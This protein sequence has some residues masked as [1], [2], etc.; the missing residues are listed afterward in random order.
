M[1]AEPYKDNPL[2]WHV[3]TNGCTPESG[4]EPA[5]PCIHDAS[6]LPDGGDIVCQVLGT[7]EQVKANARFIVEAVNTRHS[8]PSWQPIAT[9]PKDGTTILL[10]NVHHKSIE[11]G[12]W[13]HYGA[14]HTA[15]HWR[16]ATNQEGRAEIE[17]EFLTHWQPLPPP[18]AIESK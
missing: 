11:L 8:A 2:P 6:G 14:E 9:A 12:Y 13:G 10:Y 15:Y 7:S 4:G 17:D 18:P 1:S 3:G 16:E 5:F